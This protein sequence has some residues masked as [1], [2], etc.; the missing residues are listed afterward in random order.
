MLVVGLQTNNQIRGFSQQNI[1]HITTVTRNYSSCNK[2]KFGFSCNFELPRS[3]YAFKEMELTNEYYLTRYYSQHNLPPHH[4]KRVRVEPIFHKVINALNVGLKLKRECTISGKDV[5]ISSNY[6]GGE[7]AV[8]AMMKKI[9]RRYGRNHLEGRDWEL[10]LVDSEIGDDYDNSP[11]AMYF[12]GTG[13]ILMSV[14][15]LENYSDA[16]IAYTLGHEVSVYICLQPFL[17]N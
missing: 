5:S 3:Y 17:L 2:S 7:E 8:G 16:Y 9:G 12:L 10:I 4:Q 1:K 11:L 14:E 13:K 15:G 6:N